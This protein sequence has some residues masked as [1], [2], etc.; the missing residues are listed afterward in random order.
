MTQISHLD[1]A[2]QRVTTEIARRFTP[3]PSPPEAGEDS[4]QEAIPPAEPAGDAAQEPPT[5]AKTS[6]SWAEA[7]VLLGSIPG[8]SERAA[9]GILAEIG[10]NMQQFPTAGHLASWAGVC[11]GN[12][13]SAG[14]RFSGKTRKGDPWLR[15]LLIQA[16]HAAARQKHGDLAAQFRRMA[17]RRG[18]KR[19]A[20]AV[21]HSMLVIIYHLLSEGTTYEER[22]EIFFEERDRQTLERRLIRQLERLGNQVTIEPLVQVG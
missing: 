19:A 20:M 14:K 1:Q 7:V 18:G 3:A 4:Q 21:A 2:I 22:G 11:P 15:R 8:I 5:S 12:H 10:I 13:E 9:Y 6:L 16:A 17:G